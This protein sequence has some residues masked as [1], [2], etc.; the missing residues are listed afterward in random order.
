MFLLPASYLCLQAGYKNTLV[1][2]IITNF[3]ASTWMF[4][5]FS[6]ALPLVAVLIAFWQMIRY[7][8]LQHVIEIGVAAWLLIEALDRVVKA[9][10]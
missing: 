6:W 1:G 8:S 4:F 2:A 5:F 9:T 7:R 10:G 3:T